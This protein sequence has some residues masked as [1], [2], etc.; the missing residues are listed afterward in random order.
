M[1]LLLIDEVL[2]HTTRV[3]E[4]PLEKPRLTVRELIRT[5]VELLREERVESGAKSMVSAGSQERWLNDGGIRGF[6]A[7]I[8]GPAIPPERLVAEAEAAFER[9]RYM[10]LVGDRQ[11]LKLDEEVELAETGEVTFFLLTPLQ[12]G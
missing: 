1:A 4:V 3:G 6:G 5:R 2:G 11:M 7:A 9:G 10:V 8:G 12:G